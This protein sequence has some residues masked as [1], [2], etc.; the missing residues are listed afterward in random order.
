MSSPFQ[1]PVTLSQIPR[2]HY[3][4]NNRFPKKRIPP[5]H[6]P[7]FQPCRILCCRQLGTSVIGDGESNVDTPTD[8]VELD[9]H[10][11]NLLLWSNLDEIESCHGDLLAS[12]TCHVPVPDQT[13]AA[14]HQDLVCGDTREGGCKKDTVDVLG[15]AGSRD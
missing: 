2:W 5:R 1:G 11:G 8:I 3:N 13:R 10:V 12:D 14:G 9:V 15:F 4:E 7:Q 6:Q